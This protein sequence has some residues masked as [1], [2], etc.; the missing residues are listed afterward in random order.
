MSVNRIANNDMYDTVRYK[1]NKLEKKERNM[2]YL[3]ALC[4][5]VVKKLKKEDVDLFYTLNQN[6]PVHRVLNMG[7]SPSTLAVLHAWIYRRVIE[8]GGIDRLTCNNNMDLS[9]CL[10]DF[11]SGI[12]DNVSDVIN[13]FVHAKD[14]Q[15]IQRIFNDHAVNTASNIRSVLLPIIGIHLTGGGETAL[16]ECIDR[17]PWLASNVTKDDIRVFY[18]RNDQKI[19]YLVRDVVYRIARATCLEEHMS[20]MA[21]SERTVKQWNEVFTNSYLAIPYQDYPHVHL[22]MHI[23][24]SN[25]TSLPMSYEDMHGR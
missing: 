3:H 12:G 20:F 8:H 11:I 10:F 19:N 2:L 23:A 4:D 25:H 1:I 14:V 13:T 7:V 15:M 21:A 18:E 9:M 17:H 22:P 24:M 16:R 6:T 5:P